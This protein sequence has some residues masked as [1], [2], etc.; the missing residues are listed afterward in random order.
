MVGVPDPLRRDVLPPDPGC[1]LGDVCAC[2]VRVF[3]G[4]LVI[5]VGADPDLHKL[6]RP[7]CRPLLLFWQ[8]IV[9]EPARGLAVAVIVVNPSDQGAKPACPVNHEHILARSPEDH[10][11]N[12]VPTQRWQS[13]LRPAQESS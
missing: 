4:E 6:A 8:G 2:A 13:S 9:E 1:T 12:Q 10:R 11:R 5:A 3:I 7:L